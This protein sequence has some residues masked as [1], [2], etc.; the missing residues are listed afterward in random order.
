[1]PVKAEEEPFSCEKINSAFTEDG[2]FITVNGQD[3]T[4]RFQRGLLSNYRKNGKTLIDSPMKLN[5][6]RAPTDNDGVVNWSERWITKWNSRLYKHFQF[7]C[8]NTSVSKEEDYVLI[9]ATGVWAPISKYVGFA[10]EI[11]Y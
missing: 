8:H 4:A 2:D 10:T 9:Q 5:L 1:M 7:L 3:F 11:T 6:Y